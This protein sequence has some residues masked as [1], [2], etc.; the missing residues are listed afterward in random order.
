MVN[1]S[2]SWPFCLRGRPNFIFKKESW[3]AQ[4]SRIGQLTYQC[5]KCCSLPRC[6]T[7]EVPPAVSALKV[8]LIA[9]LSPGKEIVVHKHT[10]S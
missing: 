2:L 1:T 8:C 9:I 6:A 5:S 4:I 10:S 7:A 3:K